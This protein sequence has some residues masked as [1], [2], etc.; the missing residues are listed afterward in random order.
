LHI[1]T[2]IQYIIHMR[3]LLYAHLHTH[4]RKNTQI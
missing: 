2:N 3:S 4:G 1:Y